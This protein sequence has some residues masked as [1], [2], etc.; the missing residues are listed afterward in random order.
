[1]DAIFGW[2][3]MGDLWVNICL[4]LGEKNS[5]FPKASYPKIGTLAEMQSME[6]ISSVNW[7]LPVN[8]DGVERYGCPC[9]WHSVLPGLATEPRASHPLCVKGSTIA[10]LPVLWLTFQ[11]HYTWHETSHSQWGYRG[12]TVYVLFQTHVFTAASVMVLR[13]W[14]NRT[15]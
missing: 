9:S 12:L 13:G 4:R 10:T 14:A 6:A 11:S 5:C 15:G 8:S 2:C 1:M 3:I 7:L